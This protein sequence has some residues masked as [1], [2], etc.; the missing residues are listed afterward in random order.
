MAKP[1]VVGTIRDWELS[2]SGDW[3]G[4]WVGT[5]FDYQPPVLGLN[6]SEQ[7]MLSFALPGLTDED[8]A[9]ALQTSL[10]TV[11]KLW[12]SIYRRVEERL[13]ELIRD[14]WR[15]D[16]PASHRGRE[17]RRGVLAYLRERPEELRPFSR[18]LLTWLR[19]SNQRGHRSSA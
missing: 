4:S 10:P 9:G 16:L 6:R 2:G 19:G 18:K 13:P 14:P 3:H 12:S 8:L 1:H 5:L 11:K 7:R 15:P 17:K